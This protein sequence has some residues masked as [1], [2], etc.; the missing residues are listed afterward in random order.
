MPEAVFATFAVSLLIFAGFLWDEVLHG[1]TWRA[2]ASDFGLPGSVLPTRSLSGTVEE[3]FHVRVESTGK[4]AIVVELRHVDPGFTLG[5]ESLFSKL[6]APDVLT[7]DSAFDDEIRVEGDEGQALAVLDGPTRR[8]VEWLVRQHGGTVRGGSLRLS[9]SRIAEAGPAL[10][11]ALDLAALLRRVPVRDVAER[12]A[13]GARED[14]VFQVRTRKLKLLLERYGATAFAEEL[15]RES[16]ESPLADVR[17]VSARRLLQGHGTTRDRAAEALADLA[18][19][20]AVASSIRRGAFEVLSRRPESRESAVRLLEELLDDD[21]ASIRQAAMKEMGRL[22]HRPGVEALTRLAAKASPQEAVLVARTLEEIG[23]PSGR[24]ALRDL[25]RAP[26]EPVRTAAAR[27]LG[28]V[29]GL[30]EVEPLLRVA[31]GRGGTA[32]AARLAV[33]SIQ[34]R[35]GGRQAGELSLVELDPLEGAV[36]TVSD[37]VGGELSLSDARRRETT[38]RS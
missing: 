11:R 26:D 15:A 22:R 31:E 12:L 16:L 36:S 9:V 7:G 28:V 25:L 33:E 4:S 30:E 14:R 6:L 5:K 18:R 35:A 37:A 38:S 27:A 2:L 34:A 21:T 13:A 29:G 23:D 10:Q 1:G 24:P 17:F 19:T 8:Q 20:K 32:R 3:G